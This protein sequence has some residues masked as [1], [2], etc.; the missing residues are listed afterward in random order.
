MVTSVCEQCLDEYPESEVSPCAHDDCS[1]DVCDEFSEVC[2][3]VCQPAEGE[4][5]YQGLEKRFCDEHFE[6]VTCCDN[7]LCPLCY[8]GMCEV[9]YEDICIC[10]DCSSECSSCELRVC[11]EDCYAECESCELFFCLNCG[12]TCKNCMEWRCGN[13]YKKHRC[14]SYIQ[15]ITQ[16]CLRMVKKI[17]VK[18]S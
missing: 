10:P 16:E 5:G 1:I 2:P 6:S 4:C 8:W 7:S 12:E 3:G 15:K 9:D 14:I 17:W 11:A 13:C 18:P